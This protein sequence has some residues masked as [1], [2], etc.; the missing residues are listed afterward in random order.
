MPTLTINFGSTSPAPIGIT[1]TSTCDANAASPAR[2]S[3]RTRASLCC[4]H[5]HGH[6]FQLTNNG[7]RKDTVIVRPKEKVTFEFDAD[8]PGQWIAYCHNA[9]HAERGMIG[10]FS[11]VR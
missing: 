1:H 3:S 7:P 10:L 9:Y 2:S 8:N 6:S 4:T 5:L 11:Y